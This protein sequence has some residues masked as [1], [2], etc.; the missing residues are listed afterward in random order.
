MKQ[1]TPEH[2]HG[3]FAEAFNSGRVEPLLTLYEPDASL[4]PSPNEIVSG[5]VAVGAAL[6]QF[7]AVGEMAAKTRYC[8]QSGDVALASASWRIHGTEPD[9]QPIEVQGTSADL[10]R[11]Q[12]CGQDSDTWLVGVT[13]GTL[14][15]RS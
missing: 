10:L 7:Q 9:G 2:F 15:M 3:T 8:I 11:R 4:V 14:I 5:H 13:S 1:T 6:S 12:P